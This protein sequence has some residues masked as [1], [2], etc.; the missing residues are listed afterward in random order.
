MPSTT[1][2]DP[3]LIPAQLEAAHIPLIDFGPFLHGTPAERDATAR[4]IGEACRQIGFFYIINHGIP[5]QLIADTYA[6]AKRFFALPAAQKAEIA[7]EKS[8]CHRGWF[9][10][11][12]ENLDPAKQKA[13]GDLK[14]GIKIGRDLGPDHPLVLAQTPL[15]GPNQ[16]PANLPG[17]RETMQTYYDALT[18]LGRTMMHAFAMA[19]N[20][21]E[22]YFDAWLTTPMTTLGPLHYPPQTGRITEAQIG[23]GAHT[24]YGCL[25]LLAQDSSGG[26]QVRTKSGTWI[27]APPFPNSFVVN[28]GDMMERWTNNEFTSTPHR[29]IN[30]SGRERYSL[31]FFFDPNFHTPITSLT[32]NPIH[33]PTTA[34]QH[35][36]DMINASFSYHQSKMNEESAT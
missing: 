6:Q 27:E 3:A 32:P 31:P 24:D 12:G 15:H 35:L 34:G 29:V 2:L 17:W 10:I 18:T 11:G 19:L 23:A 25:T 8:A 36:L 20:L 5:A 7:I 14:E 28:I 13:A 30:I 16:W 21:P 33:P 1:Q 26:L 22:T 9:Q 4:Q